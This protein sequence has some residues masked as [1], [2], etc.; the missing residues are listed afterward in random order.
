M[1]SRNLISMIYANLEKTS[2]AAEKA[3]EI[4]ARLVTPGDAGCERRGRLCATDHDQQ[5]KCGA[6]SSILSAELGVMPC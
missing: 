4:N 1:R 2:A 6:N 3:A 5:N